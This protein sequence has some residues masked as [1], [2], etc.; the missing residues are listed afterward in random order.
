MF[1]RHACIGPVLPVLQ[2][3]H[4]IIVP[5]RTNASS[6]SGNSG[7]IPYYYRAPDIRPDSYSC[8]CRNQSCRWI[9]RHNMDRTI[10]TP[11]TFSIAIHSLSPLQDT[12][13]IDTNCEPITAIITDSAVVA[14]GDGTGQYQ[15]WQ[16]RHSDK[17]CQQTFHTHLTLSPPADCF[18]DTEALRSR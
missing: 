2:S 8:M 14:I 5:T 6:S 11:V 4:N 10:P 18:P 7:H 12:V 9:I 16:Y 13:V 15:R 17:Q 1:S 3:V